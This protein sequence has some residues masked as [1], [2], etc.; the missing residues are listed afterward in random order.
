MRDPLP[1]AASLTVTLVAGAIELADERLIEA[2]RQEGVTFARDVRAAWSSPPE[3]GTLHLWLVTS[4]LG[5]AALAQAS[6]W[7]ARAPASAAVLAICEATQVEE[8]LIAGVDDAMPRPI[9]ERELVARVRALHRRMSRAPREDHLRYG[10]LTLDPVERTAWTGGVLISVTS[11]ERAVLE[12][13]L[14]ARGRALTR[15]ELLERAWDDRAEAELSE[16]AVDNVI[17]RLRRKLPDPQLIETVRGVGFRLAVPDERRGT[18]R[19]TAGVRA[20]RPRA[21]RRAR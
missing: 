18:R 21:A 19:G 13:L 9:S 8:L 5:G 6:S 3:R 17:L 11:I 10:A 15:A 7:L 14:R 12:S 4:P 2:L 1:R 16:R 20:A